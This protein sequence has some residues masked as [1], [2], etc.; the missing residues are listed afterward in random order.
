MNLLPLRRYSIGFS[1]LPTALAAVFIGTTKKVHRYETPIFD[2]SI[3]S[4]LHRRQK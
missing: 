1:K 4:S 2:L 3:T